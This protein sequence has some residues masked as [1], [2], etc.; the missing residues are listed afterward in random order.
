[1][2]KW[3]AAIGFAIALAIL[4]LDELA[5]AVAQSWAVPDRG[6]R[7]DWESVQTKRGLTIRGYVNNDLG[8]GATNIRLVIESLDAS[9]QVAATTIGYL[10][11]SAPPFGRLY[12]EVPVKAPA[13]SYRV[14]IAAWDPVARGGA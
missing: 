5:P 9:G 3:W 1:M 8:Y 13:S 12:F 4:A 14:R 2:W 6:F 7:V 11:G 10:Q